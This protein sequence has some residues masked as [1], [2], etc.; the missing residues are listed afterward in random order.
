MT[1]FI[2]AIYRLPDLNY[3]ARD[4]NRSGGRQT[5]AFSFCGFLPK[6]ATL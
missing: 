6:A 5:A 1:S 4:E 3:F 2:S